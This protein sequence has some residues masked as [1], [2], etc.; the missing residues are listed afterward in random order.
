[1]RIKN[2]TCFANFLYTIKSNKQSNGLTISIKGS[3]IV[4]EAEE[5]Y[6]KLETMLPKLKK[7]FILITDLS[8]LVTVDYN[9]MSLIVKSMDLINSYSPSRIIRIVP[10]ITKDIGFNIMS[11]FHYSKA[12]KKLPEDHQNSIKEILGLFKK[13]ALPRCI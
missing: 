4:R 9:V 1:L 13:A 11:V 3:F 2:I 8:L 7:G 6:A 10:D 5:I 12:I